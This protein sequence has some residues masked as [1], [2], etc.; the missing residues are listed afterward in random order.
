MNEIT[1]PEPTLSAAGPRTL[2]MLRE[3]DTAM[4]TLPQTC[5]SIDHLIHGGMYARTAHVPAETIVS[6]ALL[7]RA[8]V[9]V[10][11]GDVSVFTGVDCVRL[12]GYHVLPGSAGRK[13]LFRTHADTHMTMVLLSTAQSVAEAEAEFTDEPELLMECVGRVTITGE[14]P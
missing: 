9:L 12:T 6:G 1:T 4:L 3:L 7:R 8:T 11:Q 13:Q 14:T 5:I 10:L 2:A